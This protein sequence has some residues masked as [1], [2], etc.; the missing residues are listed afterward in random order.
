MKEIRVREP[1]T[2]RSLGGNKELE[3]VSV[4]TRHHKSVE[5]AVSRVTLRNSW[6]LK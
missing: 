5:G 6:R 1:T 2:R 3:A 4:E